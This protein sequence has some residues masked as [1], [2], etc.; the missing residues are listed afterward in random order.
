M[1][2]YK[3]AKGST[4]SFGYDPLGRR[5]SRTEPDGTG[6]AYDYDVLGRLLTHTKADGTVLTHH[7][8]NPHR[9]FLTKVTEGLTTLRTYSYFADGQLNTATNAHATISRSYDAAGRLIGETQSFAS[10]PSGGFTY[11]YDTD[12]NLESHTRPDNSVVDYKYDLRNLLHKIET[13]TS[14]PPA[15]TTVA[16]YT[17][18]GRNQPLQT[19]VENGLFIATRD[20][21]HAGRLLSLTNGTLDTTSYVLTPDGRRDTITRNGSA[22]SYDYDN[23]RQVSNAEYSDLTKAGPTTK[24]EIVLPPSPTE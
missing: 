4:F 10:G 6:Q 21:D 14:P 24:L 7:Y 11:D 1:T 13:P 8:E 16:E 17:Y 15:I 19:K 23:A 18:N 5:A 9:D 2:S 22:E 12:G 20:Y 3:D